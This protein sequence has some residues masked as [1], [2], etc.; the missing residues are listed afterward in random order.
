MLS[1]RTIY[2]EIRANDEAFRLYCSISAKGESQGGWE[3]ERIAALCPDRELAPKIAHHG[4]DEDKHGRLF[5][6]LLRKRGLEPLPVPADADYIKILE[7]NGLGI[8][9]DRLRQEQPLSEEDVLAYLVHGRVTEQ[10]GAE[11]VREQRSIFGNDPELG[12]AV[13][14]IAEDEENHLAHCHEELL[15]FVERGQ[16]ARIRVLLRR[17]ALVEIRVYRDVSLTVMRRM[18]EVLRWP[19]WKRGVLG[20]G[21]WAIWLLERTF[22]WRRMTSLRPPERRNALGVPA[23]AT[24]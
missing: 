16:G 22:T 18:G 15:R 23:V 17:Y 14:M 24:R 5:L 20:A 3:N 12:K 13:R 8:P 10:R 19:A 11:E 9:H 21:I 4:Q 6:A 7:S 2:E 1:T